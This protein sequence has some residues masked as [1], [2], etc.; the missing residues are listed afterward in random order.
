[1]RE[2]GKGKPKDALDVA[3]KAWKDCQRC[4][5]TEFGDECIGEFVMYKFGY[6]DGETFCSDH[7]NSCDRSLCE[8]DQMFAKAHAAATNA[9]NQDFHQYWST[10]QNGWNP[11]SEQSCPTQGGIADMQCC[12]DSSGSS[13]FVW[14]NASDKKCCGDGSVVEQGQFC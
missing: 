4:A 1:M 14:Y 9:W 2:L 10:L 5:R 12:T 13:P 11:S 8:C 6:Q 3:C 7:I